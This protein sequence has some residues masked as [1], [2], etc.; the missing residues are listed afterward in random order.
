VSKSEWTVETLRQ[1]VE[2]QFD[3]RDREVRTALTA[4]DKRLDGMNEFRDTL[5]D[6]AATFMPR[7][8]AEQRYEQ[9]ARRISVL[10]QQ[11]T[12]FISAASGRQTGLAD[13]I[14]WLVAAAAIAVA[15]AT[16]VTQ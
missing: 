3:L 12:A 16:L 10:E 14:G 7:T 13:Y 8:E 6:Q 5:T 1:H 11:V 4:A 15:I 9:N 2:V